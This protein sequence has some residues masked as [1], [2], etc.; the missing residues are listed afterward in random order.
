MNFRKKLQRIFENETDYPITLGIVSGLYPVAFH[1]SNNFESVN[2]WQHLILFLALFVIV[3]AVLSYI[4]YKIISA[5]GFSKYRRHLLF[6]LSL[7]LPTMMLGKVYYLNVPLKITVVVFIIA[8]ASSFKLHSHYKKVVFF[9]ML[10]AVIPTM[11]VIGILISRSLPNSRE[12]QKLPDKIESARFL[13]HPNI[14]LIEPDGY[15]GAEAMIDAPYQYNTDMYSWLRSKNFKVYKQSRS[16]YPASLAS[17]ASM[18]AMKHHKLTQIPSS[19]FEMPDARRIIVG[20][21]PVLKILNANGYTSYFVVEDEY[22]QKNFQTG[23][24]DYYN[25]SNSEIPFFSDDNSVKKDVYQ[26]VRQ[27]IL[28]DSATTQPKFFFIEKLLPHHIHFDGTGVENER[29]SY[30]KKV[31][32]ANVWLKNTIQM[33]ESYDP[34]AIIMVV[35]DHGGWVG[36]ENTHQMFTTT[37][38]KLI[39]SIY[40]NL[41]AIRW[42]DGQALDYDKNLRSNVNLFRVLFARLSESPEL[43]RHLEDDSS[44]LIR[45]NGMLGRKSEAVDIQ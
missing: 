21:N 5:T 1:Y 13:H 37:D 18:F 39:R 28:N 19:P 7:V 29:M 10:L 24:Y 27:L 3:P 25:I 11:N 43:L 31:E 34:S 12:W 8:V 2:S 4:L 20:N 32:E 42:P 36:L 23:L 40:S 33:I 16:N 9:I 30:L 35:A 44:Y 22:F 17:N 15:A 26:D 14:Y 38:P 41:M 45:N 6:V